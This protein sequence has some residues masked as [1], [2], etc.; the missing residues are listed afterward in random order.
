M[1]LKLYDSVNHACMPNEVFVL[2]WTRRGVQVMKG[3]VCKTLVISVINQL[4]AQIL[5]L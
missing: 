3:R 5:V 1:Q 2:D 4:N